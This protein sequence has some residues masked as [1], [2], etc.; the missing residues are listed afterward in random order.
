M[1]SALSERLGCEVA[2]FA[3]SHCRDVVVE[4]TKAGG[5]GVLGAGSHTPEQL[6][7]ELAWIDSH[8]GGR[9]YG[10]DVIM[11]TKYDKST[12]TITGPLIDIIPQAHKDFITELLDR[13]GVP[14]L[15]PEIEQE[16]REEGAKRDRNPTRWG[17]R[18]LIDISVQHP[19][20]KMV[21]NALGVPSRDL[22]D[23]LHSSGRLVGGLCGKPEHARAHRDGGVDVL[24][25]QG[26]EAAGHTGSLSTM[27]LVPQVVDVCAGS[28]TAVLAAGGIT[29]GRHIAAAEALGA[30]GVWTGS[31]WLGVRESH[32]LPHE[33]QAVYD[34]TSSDTV[35]S[36]CMSGKPVRMLRSKFSEA[37]SQPGAPEP[38][39]APLQS[40][41]FRWAG[42]R[43][44]R[45]ERTDLFSGP[46]GQG[47]GTI[48]GEES[49]KDV[50]YRLQE[51]Y[52][53]V[54]ERMGRA[55]LG[56]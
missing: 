18:R 26:S 22:V 27:V 35:Q 50:M 16:K 49:V 3:F 51:Q 9:P 2:I 11:T 48:T 46:A 43:I 37:W 1:K 8:V 24:I 39:P 10:V 6:E 31:L 13:E 19:Q 38:L 21:V 52:I 36:K 14:R 30:D 25:A 29:E 56:A 15:P 45:A 5:F 55:A 40:V 54:I 28:D 4:V 12:E 42:A 44:A 17:A 47:I 32:W 23:E 41:L 33:R 53:D 7:H 20:V 34:A